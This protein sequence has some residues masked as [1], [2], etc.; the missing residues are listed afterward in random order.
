MSHGH[1]ATPENHADS[2]L[3]AAGT[4]D[5]EAQDVNLIGVPL[6]NIEGDR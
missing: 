2:L 3:A 5:Q 1:W 6:G 4:Q